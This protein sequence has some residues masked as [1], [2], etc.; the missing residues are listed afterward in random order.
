MKRAHG[1]QGMT[2]NDSFL[3][4]EQLMQIIQS[5]IGAGKTFE[6]SLLKASVLDKE[7]SNKTTQQ[8][9]TEV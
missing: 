8:M 7:L 4:F 3:H 6:L 9:K 5:I 2:E 1:P